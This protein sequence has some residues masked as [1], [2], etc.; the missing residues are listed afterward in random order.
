MREE[1]GIQGTYCRFIN[2]RL[3]DTLTCVSRFLLI[4]WLRNSAF[5]SFFVSTQSGRY[6]G[7]QIYDREGEH[8][9]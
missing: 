7:L 2:L 5:S 4:I 1:K 8:N 6:T 3:R 9:I